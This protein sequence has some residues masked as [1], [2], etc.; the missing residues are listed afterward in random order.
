MRRPIPVADPAVQSAAVVMPALHGRRSDALD[1]DPPTAHASP[2]ASSTTTS[3]TPEVDVVV[4]TW[5]DGEMLDRA[6]RSALDSVGVD[7]RVWV[8]D[9][10]SEPPARID[11]VTCAGEPSATRRD[12]ATVTRGR[13][14]LLRNERNRG[15]AAARNQGVSR[16]EAP[17]VLLLDSDAVLEPGCVG[18]LLDALA[19]PGV[20]LAAPVFV[21]QRPEQSAGRRP[22]LRV[23]AA[24]ALNRR[25][26]YDRTRIGDQSVWPVDFAIG[27]CQLFRREAWDA[28]GGLDEGYFY[29]PEDVDFCD[30]LSRAGWNLVQVLDARCEHPARRRHKNLLTL[31]GVRHGAAVCRHL[32]SRRLRDIGTRRGI[33]SDRFA[34]TPTSERE[35]SVTTMQD[36]TVGWPRVSRVR[37]ATREP[38]APERSGSATAAPVDVCIV[39]YGDPDG[40]G[41]LTS[42]L[43][44]H[45]QVGR[46][47]IADHRGDTFTAAVEAGA[48][49]WVDT[50]NPGF[51]IG[52]NRLVSQSDA[53][54]VLLMNPDAV[55]RPAAIEHGL[56]A[57]ADPEVVAVQ[58]LIR[59]TSTGALERAG[60]GETRPVDLWG[61]AF[62]ARRLLAIPGM[63]PLVGVL[64]RSV[65]TPH[66]RRGPS[67]PVDVETLAATAILV[68]REALL[69]AGGF[70]EAFFLYGEDLD[71]C[72][73]LRGAGGRLRYLPVEWAL[74][75]SGGTAAGWFER[76]L[77]WWEGTLTFCTRWW[78]PRDRRS[79]RMASRVMAWRMG[80]RSPGRVGQARRAFASAIRTD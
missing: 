34:A 78:T 8:V 32:L 12:A 29:G 1:I 69:S 45:R 67:E 57:L 79:A 11:H 7:V 76:E 23:K 66:L 62:G 31:Q 14:H 68:R 27:A 61:R 46:V 48:E 22:S 55:L 3:S 16:G 18:A 70:D 38:A 64:A 73:R 71:L 49:L 58:G 60:G 52:M 6:V 17:F 43:R 40:V 5:N 53:P 9:N 15:V 51:G 74:H 24:R 47:L 63:G 44:S 19:E 36:D 75:E 77:R 42:T 72:R 35:R 65:A 80:V 33:A 2:S 30:R 20:G 25:D 10:G 56:A 50:S 13:V 41:R 28:V 37:A 59:T 21:G 54:Y 39:A 26:D 4:L